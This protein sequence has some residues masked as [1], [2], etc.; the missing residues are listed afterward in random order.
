M[1]RLFSCLLLNC[2][3]LSTAH[4][5]AD[6][7]SV[8][9]GVECKPG[10]KAIALVY[11][12]IPEERRA[13]FMAHKPAT[14]WDPWTLLTRSKQRI[15]SLH[16]VSTQCTLGAQRYTVTIAPEPGNMLTEG[17]CSGH[18]G[19]SATISA[20]GKAL[21]AV[22]F[23]SRECFDMQTPIVTRVLYQSGKA[24]VVSTVPSNRFRY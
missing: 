24:P 1:R 22:T 18:M 10:E 14:M 20:N 19:A 7:A 21:Y 16:P 4:A 8:F 5:R 6:D 23:E 12:F 15:E 2:C 3:I 13:Q 9:A 11:E 17:R